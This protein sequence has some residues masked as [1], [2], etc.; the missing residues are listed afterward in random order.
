MQPD[1]FSYAN[2]A[3]LGALEELYQNYLKDPKSVEASWRHFFEGMDFASSTLPKLP[4]ER[5][6]SSDLRIYLLIDAYRKFGH[7]MASFNPI[8][9]TLPVEPPELN[10]QGLGFKQEELQ[11][12]F[13]T[14]G[15]LKE[16]LAPLSEI[17]AALQKTYC[18]KIGIEYM[19][20]SAPDLEKWI[21][22]RIEPFFPLQM[23]SENKLSILHQLNK[24]E[25]FE[26]F[27]HTKYVGQKRFSL[28]GGETMIPMLAAMLDRGAEIGVKE[29]V[30]GMAHRGRLNVL[31]N[32]LNKS[33]AHIFHEFEDHYTPDLLEGSG[34]VKYHK[35]FVGSLTTRSGTDVKVTLVANPSHLEA[36]DP[37]VEGIARAT[38]ELKAD[39]T[40]RQEVVPILIHGDAAIAG[41]GIVYETLQLSRL[42]GYCT[43]GT[44][45]LVI[46]NQIGFTTLPKD[47]RSTLYCTQIARAFSAPVFHVNAEDPE[48]CVRA[49]LLAI[50]IRHKFQCD[51][52]IDLICYRKYGHNESDEPTFTQPLEYSLIKAKPSIRTLFRDQ[53]IRDKVLDETM[54]A[55]LEN[56]FK[57]N[58]QEALESIPS[59]KQSASKSRETSQST[60]RMANPI[61]TTL[62]TET[63]VFLGQR[64]C[65]I[66]QELKCHPKIQRLLNDRLQ[67]VSQDPKVASIDWGMGEN[68]AYASLVH[69]GIHVRLSGQDVR[70]GTFSHR[71]AIWVD[72]V[73]DQKYF[74]LSHISPSQAPFDVFNSPLSEYAVLG[75]DFGYSVSYPKSLVIWEAQFGD[76]ANGAQVIID[77][78]IA[79]S[80][81]KW[82]LC[83]NLTLLLPHGNE[84]Q[85]PEHSSARIERFLQLA[86][87]NNTRI[88]NCTTPAQLFHLL[89]AQALNPEKKPLILFTPKALLRHPEC[90]SSLNEFSQGHFQEVIDDLS[91]PSHPKRLLLC[92]GKIIYDLRNE[93]KKRGDTETLILQ[94]EQLYPFPKEQLQAVL[95]KY[96]SIATIR[97]VQEEHQNMGPWEYIHPHLEALFGK[98]PV[99]Y[100]GRERSAAPAA[101]SHALHTKQQITLMNSAFEG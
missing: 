38:Q 27:L 72:Q 49:A 55:Q 26:S 86:G 3:N 57:A 22:E 61:V 89:R 52:F 90:V 96:N 9:T 60:P 36:V 50:E 77:Q 15:F 65:A 71:H 101:G 95:T 92:S 54:A 37:V 41:Q 11:A 94:V 4:Q 35:G 66:P 85:G 99:D 31:A 76:F 12:S 1:Q 34:D 98:T 97:W 83:C 17:V 8:A 24:A 80:E 40:Q 58:L 21:Q 59:L 25:I 87:H 91:P 23:E 79:S 44:L 74:P 78:F 5:A 51:V 33:Y 29:V 82:N 10:L 32:I 62:S 19:G 73:K 63:L 45:H 100:V 30:L 14:C 64:L 56:G 69:E 68:L 48:G 7:R 88:A 6:E 46:N 70:R 28:E 39:K 13:P 75:F 43:G 53:L 2:L 47:S 84:G 18:G 20:L 81:Q 16:P 67:M 42:N 93:R